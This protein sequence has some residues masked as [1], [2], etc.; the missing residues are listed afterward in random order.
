MKN[1]ILSTALLLAGF[2]LISANQLYG[3]TSEKKM[4]TKQA[5]KYTCPHH[6]DFISDKPGKCKCGA[7]LVALKSD[8][9][10][11]KSSDDKKMDKSSDSQCMKKDKMMKESKGMQEEKMETMS[12]STM[13]SEEMMK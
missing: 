3:Q 1:K 12:D 9:K 7:T 4:E 13:K 6:P 5:T 11:M 2:I 8:D 10:M